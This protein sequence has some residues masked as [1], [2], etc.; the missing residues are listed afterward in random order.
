ML[1]MSAK[2]SLMD[3][4]RDRFQYYRQ[5]SEGTFSKGEWIRVCA[6]I[7]GHVFIHIRMP[8]WK[9]PYIPCTHSYP[10]IY[11]YQ[12]YYSHVI[13]GLTLLTDSLVL[14]N[15][16]IRYF[17]MNS[18]II[19]RATLLFKHLRSLVRIWGLIVQWQCYH[20]LHEEGENS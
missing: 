6:Q 5:H 13:Q 10:L 2:C 16:I 14:P 1:E 3:N 4:N 8:Q 15:I 12:K 19:S 7:T 11:Y 17:S 9:N 20:V 18:D